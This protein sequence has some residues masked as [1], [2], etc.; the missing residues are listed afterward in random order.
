MLGAAR[1]RLPRS[2]V[3]GGFMR[4]GRSVLAPVLVMVIA[5]ITGGW[6]LQRG[7]GQVEEAGAHVGLVAARLGEEVAMLLVEES[8]G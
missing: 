2:T 5:M 4:N 7:V 1:R 8:E 6:F 3:Y